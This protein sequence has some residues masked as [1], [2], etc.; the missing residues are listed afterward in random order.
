M[1]SAVL[2]TEYPFSTGN[3]DFFPTARCANKAAISWSWR[4][5]ADAASGIVFLGVLGWETW[6]IG[7]ELLQL[8]AQ[9]AVAG[10]GYLF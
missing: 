5:I 8:G 10:G 2:S 3:Y 4:A 9:M 6:R 7:G 1:A